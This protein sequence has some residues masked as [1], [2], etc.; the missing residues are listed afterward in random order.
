MH[1]VSGSNPNVCDNSVSSLPSS[2]DT[3]L[4][5]SS[6][7]SSKDVSP[8]KGMRREDA[9]EA[10]RIRLPVRCRY[11]HRAIRSTYYDILGVQR[12]ATQEE[13][14]SSYRRWQKEYKRV[15]QVD[16]QSADAHDAVVVEARNVLGHPVL[17]SEYDRTLP[18]YWNNSMNGSKDM[19][20]R[21]A[22]LSSTNSSRSTNMEA[23]NAVRIT[24]SLSNA[25]TV[26]LTPSGLADNS[27]W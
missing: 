13:I 12:N 5:F 23:T 24:N 18:T 2:T 11:P 4:L 7:N 1:D 9:V 8:Q 19:T 20:R 16:Q 21:A 15:K 14:I 3:F 25:D 10:F 17:R 6:V 27:I 22:T 26:S